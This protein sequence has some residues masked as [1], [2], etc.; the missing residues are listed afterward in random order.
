MVSKSPKAFTRA[1]ALAGLVALAAACSAAGDRAPVDGAAGSE[2]GEGAAGAGAGGAPDG[3]GAPGLGGAPGGAG[4]P[5]SG[6]AAGLGGAVGGTPTIFYLDVSG[7]V[8]T[9]DAESP[10]PRTLVASAGQGP[11]GIAVDLAGG[12]IYWTN[13]GVPADDDGLLRRSDLDGSHVVTIIPDGG[14]YTPKQLK[15]DAA[16]GKLYWSDREGMRVQRANTDGSNIETLV[17]V[18]TGATAR[19]DCRTTAS[20]WPS[21]RRVAGSTGRRRG[22]TTAGSARSAAPTFRCPRPRPA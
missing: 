4:A 13:M 10:S 19:K 5:G 21:T 16:G 17:T 14:T 20:A 12:H 11:D 2:A 1:V 7:K 6:G 8:M 15:L 18:A 22:P 3:G 9:A